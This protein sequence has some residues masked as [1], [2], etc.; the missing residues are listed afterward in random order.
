MYVYARIPHGGG[1]YRHQMHIT[2]RSRNR[3]GAARA[4]PRCSIE[5]IRNFT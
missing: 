3:Q 1:T 5:C 4:L 2:M